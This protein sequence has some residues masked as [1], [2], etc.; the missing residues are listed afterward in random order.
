[1]KSKQLQK[2]L[3]SSVL[4]LVVLVT[5]LMGTTFAW[6]TD[7][8]TSKGNIIQTGTLDV[9]LEYKQ[10]WSDDWAPVDESTK[11]FKEGVLYEP[12]YTEVVYLRVSNAG[13]LAL[14]YM[15]SLDIANEEGS[16]NVYGEE[17]KISDYLKVGAYAQDEYGLGDNDA[18]VLM[19]AM[20]GTR[21]NAL[22]N[23]ALSPLA[24]A[25]AKI[26]DNA[27]ILPGDK[28]A[29]V[30]AIVLTMP[31]SVGNEANARVGA[32]VPYVEIGLH[33]FATQYTYEED[34]FDD[35]YDANPITPTVHEVIDAETFKK[36]F[37]EGGVAKIYNMNIF[38][39]YAELADGKSLEMNT[40]NST[41]SCIKNGEDDN[42][43]I[44]NHG[45]LRLTGDGTITTQMKG[46]I[47]NWGTLYV[48]NLNISVAGTKYGFHCKKGEVEIN[49]LVLNAQRGGLN[50]QGGKV[51]INSGSITTTNY[52]QKIG[53][54]VYVAS[55][56]SAEVVINGG[57]FRYEG[58]YAKH[59]IL[60]AGQ[61]ATIIVNGGTFGKGGSNA[62]DTWISTANG[63]KVII[64]GGSF[65]FDPSAYV[66]DGYQ[67]IKGSDG[68]WTVSAIGG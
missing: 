20:F 30:I 1:L 50:V 37:E 38:D 2:S 17:F 52:A 34:S 15:L 35:Q 28:T 16:V 67:A 41:I 19:P 26:R 10:S 8:A 60:Y 5:A 44:V 21:E 62:K 59:R 66:D 4:V 9:V 14:K 42:Y 29:H 57:D 56:T 49:D 33:L 64:R 43:V 51:T 48:N 3:V 23:V 36:A 55:E 68:W 27:S 58:M 45:D 22:R 54:L 32:T 6:F 24:T 25:R 13:S 40:N 65:Q 31:D 7:S 46:S 18:D 12:G 47:E 53:Y 11:V 39:A 63:G 61:N